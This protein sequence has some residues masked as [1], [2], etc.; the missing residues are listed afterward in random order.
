MTEYIPGS[1]YTQGFQARMKGVSKNSLN[2]ENPVFMQEWLTGWDDAH[3]KII[4]EARAGGGCSK[5]KCCK[6]F[7]QD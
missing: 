1:A 4:E 5:P 2:N 6:N 3:N 7:I